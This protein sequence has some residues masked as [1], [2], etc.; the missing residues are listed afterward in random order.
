LEKASTIGRVCHEMLYFD[1]EKE[2]FLAIYSTVGLLA[3]LTWTLVPPRVPW[4]EEDD[5]SSIS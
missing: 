3:L 5:H 2:V 4:H 1:A